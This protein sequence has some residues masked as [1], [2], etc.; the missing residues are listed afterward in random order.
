[1]VWGAP[2]AWCSQSRSVGLQKEVTNFA[3]GHREY[4]AEAGTGGLGLHGTPCSQQEPGSKLG[5]MSAL[6]GE[7]A[8]AWFPSS[9][10][11][12]SPHPGGEGII[13]FL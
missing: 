8:Q 5:T 4:L 2:G 1:M 11:P 10:F 3:L 13:A 9:C 7:S 12:D 6:R